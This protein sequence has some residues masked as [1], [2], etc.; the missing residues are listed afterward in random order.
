MADAHSN[1]ATIVAWIAC[2]LS[3]RSVGSPIAA[4]VAATAISST[5]G[6]YV[7]YVT[8]RKIAADPVFG[9]PFGPAL[10]VGLSLAAAAAAL[11]R[12]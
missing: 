5:V 7:R 8:I 11:Y 4:A 3:I 6:Q 9:H 2:F 12:L 1:V 10:G